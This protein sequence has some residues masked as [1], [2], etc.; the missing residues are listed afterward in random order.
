MGI[1]LY[2]MAEVGQISFKKTTIPLI[3]PWRPNL[4]MGIE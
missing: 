3:I 1:W 4:I 2:M